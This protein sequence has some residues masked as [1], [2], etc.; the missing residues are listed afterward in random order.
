MK[1]EALS[2]SGF[3]DIGVSVSP[4]LA[5]RALFFTREAFIYAR[6]IVR[7]CRHL[8]D[9]GLTLFA[10]YFRPTPNLRRGCLLIFVDN[11]LLPFGVEAAV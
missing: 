10:A 1:A 6:A 8:S 11:I 9:R 3:S 7:V 2:L 4:N 5:R